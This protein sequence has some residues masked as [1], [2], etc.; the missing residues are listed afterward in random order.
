M[1]DK[2]GFTLIEL[3]LVTVIIAILA[4]SVTVV[5]RGR[6]E[7]ARFSRAMY[8]IQCYYSAIDLYAL[9]HNDKLPGGLN[10]LEGRYVRKVKNDPWGNP[11]VFKKGG[12]GGYYE[13]LSCGADGRPGGGDDVTDESE[14]SD[15]L[16][17][18][19]QQ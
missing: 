15:F 6:T 7:Q 12:K 1:S 9:D 10:D 3:I 4:G 13:I 14:L 5:F 19:E 8:D 11:Y 2:S 18:M 16:E 17:R